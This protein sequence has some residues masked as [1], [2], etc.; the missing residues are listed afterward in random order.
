VAVA[1]VVVENRLAVASDQQVDKAVVVIVGRRYGHPIH[2][3]IK[4]RL[5][6]HIGKGAVAV[7]AIEMIVRRRCGLFL[8]RYG[9][10]ESS[11]GR[12]LTT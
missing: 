9:C 1:V 10:M 11:S 6:R 2:I 4:A 12:P 5:F 8:E 3:R 7:V